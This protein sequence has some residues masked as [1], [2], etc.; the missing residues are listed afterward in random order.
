MG[1]KVKLGYEG[2]IHQSGSSEIVDVEDYGFTDEE[3][4]AASDREK[5]LVAEEWA[6]NNGLEIYFHEV[7]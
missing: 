2:S 5:Q 6:F 7:E 1:I 4:M 3:W